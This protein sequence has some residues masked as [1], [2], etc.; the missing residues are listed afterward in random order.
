MARAELI[1]GLDY[2]RAVS[3]ARLM[4]HTL[5]R[6]VDRQPICNGNVETWRGMLAEESILR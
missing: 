1:V 2:C 3:L 6:A 5:I 4:R